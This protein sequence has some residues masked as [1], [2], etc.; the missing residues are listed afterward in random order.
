MGNS[1]YCG[2]KARVSVW[3]SVDG[4]DFAKIG[5]IAGRDGGK[6]GTPGML[7]DAYFDFGGVTE[8]VH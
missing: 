2:Y 8:E 1:L 6:P 5:E 4:N 7:Y 3:A